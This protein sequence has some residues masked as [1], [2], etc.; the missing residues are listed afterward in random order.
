[1]RDCMGN[2]ILDVVNM[3]LNGLFWNDDGTVRYSIVVPQR[4][5]SVKS[6]LLHEAN[7][8]V[9]AFLA[10]DLLNLPLKGGESVLAIWIVQIYNTDK[11]MLNS[12]W[13]LSGDGDDLI[14]AVPGGIHTTNSDD[15]RGSES[16]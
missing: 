3:P 12:P 2:I 11:L 13:H 15:R 16:M 1:M 10:L 5:T 9:Y 4:P 6:A 7:N 8:S 14:D